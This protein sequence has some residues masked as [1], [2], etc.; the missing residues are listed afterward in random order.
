MVAEAHDTH[1]PIAASDYYE[2]QR[3][4]AARRAE[5]FRTERIPKFLSYFERVLDSA[6]GDWLA[7]GG[8]WSYA[9]LSLFHLVDGLLYAFPKRMMS[10]SAQYPKVMALHGRVA[11]L[12]ELRDYFASGRR[13][14]F[15]DGIFR[16]YPE[17]DGK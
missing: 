13:L 14:P 15:G 2:D 4:E 6:Q 1:H 9:D 5:N 7:E 17:L 3:E 12:P 16:H 8:R 11:N 10:V